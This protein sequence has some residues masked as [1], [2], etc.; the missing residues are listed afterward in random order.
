VGFSSAARH[1]K[2]LKFISVLQCVAPEGCVLRSVAAVPASVAPASRGGFA[3][4]SI[5]FRPA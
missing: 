3:P 2:E 1:V 4:I 5:S